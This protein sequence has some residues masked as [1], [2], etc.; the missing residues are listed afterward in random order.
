MITFHVE[1]KNKEDGSTLKLDVTG[2]T[3]S[4]ALGKISDGKA[5]ID[6]PSKSDKTKSVKKAFRSNREWTIASI[7]QS[8][9]SYPE[10][11]GMTI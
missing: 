7:R 1:L 2:E 6:A 9:C 8:R 5:R 11:E 10:M 3:A 4:G